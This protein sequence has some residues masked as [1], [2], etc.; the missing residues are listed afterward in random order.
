MAELRGPRADLV[1]PRLRSFDPADWSQLGD[2]KWDAFNRWM[3][4]RAAWL[5]AHPGSGALGNKVE[6]MRAEYQAQMTP[7]P[8][9][10]RRKVQS[11]N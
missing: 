2:G 3:A 1:D 5:L 8:G 10:T 9:T 11:G 7:P 4:A 6:R